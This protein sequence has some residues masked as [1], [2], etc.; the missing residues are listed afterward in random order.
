[1]EGILFGRHFS[2]HSS[3][4]ASSLVASRSLFFPLTH[5]IPCVYSP[6]AQKLSN[7]RRVLQLLEMPMIPTEALLC[8]YLG[9]EVFKT[10]RILE[11][12]HVAA[13]LL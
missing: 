6:V 3:V 8:A 5:S 2:P 13:L 12:H 11:A 10:S 1:M 9:A 4:P 7:Y